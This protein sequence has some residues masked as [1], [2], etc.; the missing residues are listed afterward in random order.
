MNRAQ[1]AI[2][3]Y[4]TES[5]VEKKAEFLKAFEQHATMAFQRDTT[6]VVTAEK[7]QVHVERLFKIVNGTFHNPDFSLEHYLEEIGD[8]IDRWSPEHSTNPIS[9][10][11]NECELAALRQVRNIVKQLIK[12]ALD[13][14]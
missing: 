10:L 12:C 9:N 6:K 11:N 5:F 3:E 1:A 13:D 7:V 2:L 8:E 14:A 4:H